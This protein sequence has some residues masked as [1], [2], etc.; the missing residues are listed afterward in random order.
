M[1][2]KSSDQRGFI[3]ILSLLIV[4]SV[5]MFFALS[6]L[7]DGVNNASLSLSSIYYEDARINSHSCIED[8]LYRLKLEQ[9]FDRNLDY[10]ISEA[11][12]CSTEMTWFASH[13][14]SPQVTERLVNVLV[15][16]KS[17][18]FIRKYLYELRVTRYIVNS[19]D[20]TYGYTN[21]IDY[22]AVNE[23]GT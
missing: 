21:T 10:T 13:V 11:N 16:G 18:D 12:T 3:A 23:Q 2:I 20:G 6:M 9:Q 14:I 4:A 15:T 7:M 5:S 17:H 1:A 19:P 22:I 8:T